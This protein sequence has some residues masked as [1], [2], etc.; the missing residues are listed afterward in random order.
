MS[1]RPDPPWVSD[2]TLVV[3]AEDIN[4][5]I[6]DAIAR[7]YRLPP[8]R[9]TPDRQ[10]APFQ[11]HEGRHPA[12]YTLGR[13]VDA[14]PDRWYFRRPPVRHGEAEWEIH[15]HPDNAYRDLRLAGR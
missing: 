6:P 8:E 11:V 13:L 10:V 14:K 5:A 15:A 9:L 7:R 1:R 12:S 2:D 4:R 3:I